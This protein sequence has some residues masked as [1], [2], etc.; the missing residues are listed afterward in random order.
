MLNTWKSGL[1]FRAWLKAQKRLNPFCLL[2]ISIHSMVWEGKLGLSVGACAHIKSPS[3]C[4]SNVWGSNASASL[5]STGEWSHGLWGF[6]S[7][8]IKQNAPA[9]FLFGVKFYSP[10]PFG[11]WNSCKPFF[12]K[13]GSFGGSVIAQTSWLLVL[14][15]IG[16]E[17]TY[18][19]LA[20]HFSFIRYLQEREER[21]SHSWLFKTGILSSFLLAGV[22]SMDFFQAKQCFGLSLQRLVASWE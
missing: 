9:I 5:L 18:V 12:S 1:V 2:Y 15:L 7:S 16:G 17:Q 19:M 8:R 10:L 6:W 20:Q 3:R 11:W 22:S 13:K 14:H 4:S 21:R